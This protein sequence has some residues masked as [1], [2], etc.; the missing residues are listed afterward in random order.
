MSTH[1]IGD[2]VEPP[3]ALEDRWIRRL[4]DADAVFLVIARAADIAQLS[5]AQG[6]PAGSRQWAL[7]GRR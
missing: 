7:V 3:L 1:A 2:Q 4:N 6:Q 5:H